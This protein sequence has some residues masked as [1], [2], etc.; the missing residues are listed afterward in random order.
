ML[1]SLARSGHARARQF[2][3]SE[4]RGHGHTTSE[5][6]T[7]ASLEEMKK[8]MFQD[9]VFR[10][11]LAEIERSSADPWPVHHTKAQVLADGRQEGSPRGRENEIIDFTN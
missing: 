5:S 4:R 10:A 1:P 7:S 9:T 2:D 11:R 8:A 6:E 3:A